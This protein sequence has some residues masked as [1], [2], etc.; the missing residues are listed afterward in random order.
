M[1][2]YGYEINKINSLKGT[3]FL[4]KIL[5]FFTITFVYSQNKVNLKATLD[6]KANTIKINQQITYS[7]AS[8][9]TLKE[10]Y[11]NDWANSFSSKITPLGKRF[12][13]DFLK[14]F[15]YAKKNERGRTTIVNITNKEKT[16]LF[17][18]RPKKHPDIIKLVLPTPLLPNQ[19]YTIQ[20]D[21]TIKIPSSKFTKYGYDSNGNFSLRYWY[22]IPSVYKNGW[23]HYSN[24]NLDDF[25]AELSDFNIEFTLPTNYFL[26]SDLTIEN[27]NFSEDHEQ[28]T[29]QLK[30]ENRNEISLYVEKKNSFYTFP[31]NGVKFISNIQDNDLIPEMKIVATTRIIKFLEKQLGTYPFER[32]ITSENEYKNNPVYGLNQLPDILRP[33]PDGFQYEIKQLKTIT[34]N[35]LERTLIINPRYDSWIKDAIHV[36][37]M[38]LY[39]ETY[40]PDMKIVG[41]LSK[42]IGLRWFHAADLKFND[43]YFL[44]YKNMARLFLDQSLTMPRDSLVK[45]NANIA[46][47]Y[48]AGIGFKYLEDYLGDKKLMIKAIKSYYAQYVLKHSSSSDFQN[49]LETLSEKNDTKWFFNDFVGSKKHLDF[50]IKSIK[51]R[52]DSIDVYI[53][54]KGNHNMPISLHGIKDKQKVSK[55]WVSNINN[56]KKVTIKNDK[57]DK[58]ILD[59][60]QN[61]PEINRRNNYRNL[62]WI[63]NKPFQMRFFEDVEDPRY[64]QIFFIPEFEYNVYDGFSVGTKFYNKTLI[65]RQFNY[66]ITP[67][68]GFGSNKLLGSGSIHYRHQVADNGLWQ[69]LYNISGSTFSYEEDLLFRR[70]SPSVSFLYRPKDLRSNKRQRLIFRYI[71]VD[72]DRDELNPVETPDYN[73]FNIRF[74]K[75]DF[76]LTNVKSYLIDYQISQRFSK[77][78]TTFNYRKI[79]LNNRQLNLRLYA[80]TFIYNDTLKDED[81]FSFA[82]DRPTD[83][84]FDYSYLG[85]SED[86][87]LTSQQIIIAEGGFKSQLEFPFANQWLTTFNAD[88]NI[89]NWIYLYGD[90]GFVKNRNQRPKFQYDSGIRVS[91]VAD[92][93][94]LFFPLYSNKGWEIAQPN[95]DQQIRFIITLSPQVLIG[96]FTREWY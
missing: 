6:T 75:S 32:L 50:K 11:L 95:Y 82:L 55:T 18:K 57:M 90:V 1:F 40:Y 17:W 33:F 5:F 31:S 70:F 51:K 25:Y 62:K 20:L 88:T 91:L 7:N 24:K 56:I 26:T 23:Q 13:E 54:N 39:T 84:L 68:Y 59:Y 93:F 79:F 35:Y 29:I 49:I 41:N 73:V 63:F 65:R 87:G 10:I 28:K 16:N 19:S 78:S 69:I 21:Y 15:Y 67:F 42:I 52:K 14:R 27:T 60:D 30:G 4:Y 46:N 44:G 80:G 22:L 45:F 9:D 3:L 61:I 81:F 12:S 72:R 8:N 92:Y 96:L 48:K 36:Y 47:A 64:H 74:R 34:E 2:F 89:W 37:M 86:A 58:L 85:R 76:N 53:Q 83:Y 38:I 77:I 94:E 71:D 66:A 43:Q